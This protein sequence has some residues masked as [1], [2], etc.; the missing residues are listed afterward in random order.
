MIVKLFNF[1]KRENSTSQPIS[2]GHEFNCRLKDDTSVVNPVIIID[3]G[4]QEDPE[5]HL[6]NYAYIEDFKRYYFIGDIKVL[7]GMLWEYSLKCDILA[8]YKRDI[9]ISTIYLLRCSRDFDGNIID[10]YYPVK[11][12]YHDAVRRKYSPWFNNGNQIFIDDGCFIL[13]V[14]A[15]PYSQTAST[16]GSIKYIAMTRANLAVLVNYLMTDG[17]ITL[18]GITLEGVTAQAAKAIIDPLQFIKSCQWSPLKYSDVGTSEVQNLVIWSW[19]VPGAAYKPLPVDMPYLKWNVTFDDIPRHPQSEMRGNYLNTEPFTKLMINLPPFGIIDLDT[20]LASGTD[21]ILCN[22]TY[23]L[24]TGIGIL[25]IHYDYNFGTPACRIKS[26]IGVPIQLTQVYNDY[27]SAAG[28][29]AGGVLGTI[30]SIFTGN[31]AGAVISGIGAVTSAASAMKP[32][33]SSAGGTGGF[34]DLDGWACLYAVFYDL[35]DEDRIHAGRPLCKM[36]NM[37]TMAT[38]IYCLAL[39][40]D[41]PINGTA[42]EQAQLKQ[43]LESGFFY[44]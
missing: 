30:G 7:G 11:T 28:G 41:I 37:S 2:T 31:A 17:N 44:E 3:F 33:Q 8:T 4:D 39:G 38:G 21:E 9:S 26:Q 20:T 22:I 18:Q 24:I 27:I 34:S 10:N 13:G 29:V 32:V 1:Y 36:V 40:G 25:E 19:S 14:V 42:G 12:S 43:Y 35:P 5:A 6:F 23:D 16:Y 15:Q